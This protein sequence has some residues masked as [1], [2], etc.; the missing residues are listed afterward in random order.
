M[1]RIGGRV[2][3]R[4]RVEG[5][6]NW[7]QSGGALV[8]ANHASF[9]DPPLVGVA[10]RHRRMN[11]LARKTL[12]SGR[13]ASW[14]L[15]ALNAIAIDREGTG[16]GGLKE[17]MRRLKQAEMVLIFPEGTRSSDGTLQ[18]FE[19]G[20][21]ALARRTRVPIVPISIRGASQAWPRDAKWPKPAP[22]TLSV[23]PQISTQMIA[24][25]SDKELID[26]VAKRIAA[27]LESTPGRP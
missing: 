15:T 8:C 23:G 25:M 2:F 7:P 21:I 11:F 17:A 12:F 14:V 13:V 4:F 16:V 20:F 26:E 10:C 24:A 22:V 3:L 19:P 5:A 6:E 27:G 18:P 1:L 9:L